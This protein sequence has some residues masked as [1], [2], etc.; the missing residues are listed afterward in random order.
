[1]EWILVLLVAAGSFGLCYLLDKGFTRIFRGTAQHRSGRSVRLSKRYGAAGIVLAVVGIAAI[2]T[3][4][5]DSRVL[6]CGGIVVAVLG[7]ALIVYY[8]TFG[9]FYDEDSFLLTTFGRRSTLYRYQD[10]RCQQLYATYGSTVIELV[11]ADGRTV[12]LQSTM[13]DAYPFLDTAFAGWCR[14]KGLT[15]QDC[16]FH[17]PDNS[18]WFP[19]PEAQ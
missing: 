9:I 8:M 5:G 2:F 19:G 12:Q 11:M 7:V 4:L 18:C 13:A 10:I 16:P 3:G 1:M 6:L 17:D 14:Q 15:E